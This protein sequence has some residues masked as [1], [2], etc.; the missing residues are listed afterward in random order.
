[1]K[2]TERFVIPATALLMLLFLVW[3]CGKKTEPATTSATPDQST[4]TQTATNG[5]PPN[6]PAT[7]A[8]VDSTAISPPAPRQIVI[9]AGTPI[10]VRLQERLSSATARARRA[11]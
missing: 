4:T 3:S 2:Q 11:L 7:P 10:T 5:S 8:P 1:M 6:G 9:P